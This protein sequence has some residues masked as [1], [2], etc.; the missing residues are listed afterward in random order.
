MSIDE[1]PKDLDA[2]HQLI[3]KLAADN[4]HLGRKL[5]ELLRNKYGTKSEAL[6]PDQ[7]NLFA[8]EILAEYQQSLLQQNPSASAKN[9]QQGGGGRNI[10]RSDLPVE[11][12][13]KLQLDLSGHILATM[14]THM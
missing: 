2:C 8:K 4:E 3:L 1:L 9:K 11:T 10:N 5:Q 13:V 6:N 12:T 14:K 7:L